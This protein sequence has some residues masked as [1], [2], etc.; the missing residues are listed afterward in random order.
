[1]YTKIRE[2]VAE[3]LDRHPRRPVLGL[4]L[5][6]GLGS[7]AELFSKKTVIPFCELSHFPRSTVPGHSGN[8]VLGEAEGVPAVALQGRVHFYEGYTMAEVAYPTRVLGGLGIRQLIVTNAAGGINVNFRPGDLMLIA[9]H[10]N[11]MGTNPLIGKNMDEL[12]PRFPDMTEAYDSGM[13]ATALR[14]AGDVGVS[15]FQGVYAGLAGPSYETPAEIRMLRSLGADAVGMS[16]VPE[17]IVANHMGIGV[18]GLSCITN[19]AAGILPR[20]L[21]HQEVM[22][23]TEMVKEKFISLLRGIVPALPALSDAGRTTVS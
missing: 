7:Y 10:I 2:T 16:T 13:R 15:L 3:I 17:V 1:M 23:T 11:L 20:K 5:G 6:S 12:G 18:L 22:D 21:T 9:D 4:I 14:V 8:L 19:M